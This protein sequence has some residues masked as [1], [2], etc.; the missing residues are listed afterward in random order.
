[1]EKP[2]RL[3][4]DKHCEML[5]NLSRDRHTMVMEGIKYYSG[6]YVAIAGGS[7]ALSVSGNPSRLLPWYADVANLTM[8]IVF[9]AGALVVGGNHHAWRGYRRKLHEL[10]V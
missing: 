1:M 3:S 5:T 4:V 10:A 7:M 8:F 9:I 2:D 6:L